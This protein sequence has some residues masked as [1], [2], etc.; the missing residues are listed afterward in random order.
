MSDG[1]QRTDGGE[2]MSP[3]MMVL[4]VAGVVVAVFLLLVMIVW[5]IRVR[6]AENNSEPKPMNARKIM[7]DTREVQESASEIME[8][9]NMRAGDIPE[10]AVVSVRSS[11]GDEKK[12]VFQALLGSAVPELS[13]LIELGKMIK[14]SEEGKAADTPEEKNEALRKGVERML[15]QHPDNA[16][17]RQMLT[18]L[19]REAGTAD[20][21][22]DKD[23]IQVFRI[24][25]KTAIRVDGIDFSSADEINDPETR[26]KVRE[27]IDRLLK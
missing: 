23:G 14:E 16:F 12:S 26:R 11:G 21:A 18:S 25:G 20:P 1:P 5:T 22:V 15:E 2:R 9:V 19:P 27:L 13:T 17:L 8:R 24:G 6:R 7:R 4:L 3:I 10:P